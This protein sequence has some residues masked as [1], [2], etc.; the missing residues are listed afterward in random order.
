MARNRN[1]NAGGGNW[2][3]QEIKAVWQKGSKIEG[4]NPDVYRKDICGTRIAFNKHGDVKDSEGWE[5]DHIK[6]VAK[7]G[8]DD[9]SN[10]QPL[11][12]ET[13]KSKSDTYPWKCGM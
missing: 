9:L 8:K 3:P 11:Q 13:N 7:D 5:I 4:L 10:L 2:T 6:P 12:W 1:T